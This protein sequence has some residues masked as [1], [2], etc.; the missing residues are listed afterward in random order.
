MNRFLINLGVFFS[1][2]LLLIGYFALR[3]DGSFDQNYMRFTT[4]RQQSLILGVSRAAAGIKP[5]VLKT[6]MPGK[7]FFNFSFN[8]YI[9]P[10]G[11]TYFKA[12]NKK[13]DPLAIDGIFILSI[14]P[15][16]FYNKISAEGDSMNFRE[17]N[18]CLAKTKFVNVNPNI[19]YL[20]SNY[21]NFIHKYC[22]NNDHVNWYLH[23]DVWLELNSFTDTVE[24]IKNRNVIIKKMKK[25]IPKLYFSG[26]RWAYFLKTIKFLQDH[27]KVYLIRLPVEKQILDI[28]NKLMPAF[29]SLIQSITQKNDIPF[30]DMTVLEYDFVFTDGSHLHKKSS[31]EV[32]RLIGEWILSTNARN[33]E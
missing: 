24:M 9:S 28:E 33:P 29:D 4:G 5:E 2:V 14:S 22:N 19:F 30:F 7:R 16:S 18:H 8:A 27:G 21:N 17:L 32:S 1:M 31:D 23:D 6:Y 20:F 10:Y 11:P 25:Q 12:I 3:V 15:F 13:L 26:I